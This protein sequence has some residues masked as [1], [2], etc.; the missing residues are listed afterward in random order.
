L[1][2]APLVVADDP[3]TPI[4]ETL[5]RIA[6]ERHAAALVVGAHAHGPI[7]GGIARV[8]VREAECPVLVVR[9]T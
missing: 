4:P 6:K 8:V 2:A 9:E 5:L 3:G 1:D 7:L